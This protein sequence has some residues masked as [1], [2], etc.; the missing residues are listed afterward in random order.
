MSDEKGT[1]NNFYRFDD[2]TV[3]CENFRV[4]K[5]GQNVILK[6]RDFDVLIYLIRN[7]GRVVEKQEL[8][9]QVWKEA[10]VSDNALTK[11]IKEIRHG[12]GDQADNPQYIETVPKRGYRF[13]GDINQRNGE[14]AAEITLPL[15]AD[16]RG[17]RPSAFSKPAIV[18]A[19]VT[20]IAGSAFIAWWLIPRASTETSRSSPIRSIAVLPFKPLNTDSRD[21]S[22]EMG[23]A[24]TLITRLSNLKQVTVRPMSAVRNYTDIDQDLVKAGNEMVVEAVLDG[25]IQ[26]SGDRVRVTVRL[27]DVRNGE[28]LWSEQFDESFTDIFKVQ[29]S[30]AERVTNAL[31]LELSRQE[32]EQL[33]KHYTNNPEAYQLYLRGQLI[34]N[35]RRQNWIEQSLEYYRQA[36]EKDPNF[37]LAYIGMADCYIMSNGHHKMPARETEAKARPAI[38]KALEIDNT[39]AQAH[40]ALAEL[41]YQ[42]EYDWENAEREFKKAVELN[43]NV[44][45]IRQAYGW[46]L[47]SAG[48]FEEAT[49]QMET[50]RKLD[51]SSLTINV[52]RGR[53]FYYSR[54][55]DQAVQHFQNIVAVEPNDNSSYRSLYTIYEQKKMY[56]EAVDVY[57]KLLDMS[58]RRPELIQEY[59]EAFELSG[60]DGFLR[61]QLDRLKNREKTSSV[62]P[63]SLADLYVR[64]G[65]KDEALTWL[66]KAVEVRDPVIIQFKIEPAYD[67]L[68]EDPRFAKL[69]RRVGLEP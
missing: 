19:I 49:A 47:M 23:M 29:D 12:L 51:P 6:P 60:W 42:Y 43:P 55:Y 58:G 33:A 31:T 64:L 11:I 62:R 26:K 69:I 46:F 53:L 44:A 14:P 39:L 17:V 38:M 10:F 5:N 56:P 54:Q 52:G 35:G 13:I 1:R 66:E 61:M 63:L 68:R 36:V 4:Q 15:A 3:D 7:S 25:S 40:N 20:L 30:I 2:V 48:R 65:Q 8:F 9:E 41:K 45:W 27:V 37:A 34:W 22:L 57:L 50:A 16:D 32:K 28:P 59:R 24:E 18:L 67:S 21:E